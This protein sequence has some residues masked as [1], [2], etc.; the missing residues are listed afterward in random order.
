MD[1]TSTSIAETP[2]TASLFR[3]FADGVYTL[4]YRI[5]GDRHLAEDAVQETF[6]KVMKSLHTYRGDGPLAGWLYR[7]GYRETIAI[8]RR[9]RDQ[10]MDV[11]LLSRELEPSVENVEKSVVE[12]ELAE[13][14]DKAIGSLTDPLRGA[15]VLRDIEGL[16]TAE[17]A[18][19][20]EISESAVK[21]RLARAREALR[22]ELQE[23]LL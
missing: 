20:L 17:V 6:I 15:F 16:S 21:M 5:L 18:T 7:I 13:R 2:S 14:L 22:V 1:A 19:A 12:R 4:A 23:Y 10:P 3:E 11:E 8:A 9:R